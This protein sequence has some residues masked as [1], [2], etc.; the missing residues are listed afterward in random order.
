MSRDCEPIK[1]RYSEAERQKWFADL[2]RHLK[3]RERLAWTDSPAYL[4]PEGFSVRE[5]NDR[6]YTTQAMAVMQG[7]M[8]V[9][10]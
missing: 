1:A 4:R 7:W 3:G 6:H 5:L 9:C 8:P 10:V 2:V